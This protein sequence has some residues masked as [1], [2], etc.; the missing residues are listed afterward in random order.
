MALLQKAYLGSTALFRN[1]S[2]FEDDVATLVNSTTGATVTASATTHAK[3]AWTQLL[4]SSSADASLI[5]IGV[6][7]FTTNADTSS[8]LDIGTGASGSETVLIG[9]IAI[10]GHATLNANVSTYIPIPIRVA[11]G[12]R[13]AARI[14]SVVASRAA[15]VRIYLIDTGD[16]NQAPTS[17]DVI[18]A[19]TAT[20][21][22][23]LMSGA[24]GTWVQVTASTSRAYRAVAVVP[25]LA[26]GEVAIIQPMIY[27]LGTGASGSEVEIGKVEIDISNAEFLGYRPVLSPLVAKNIPSGTRLAIKH[28]I[29]S[30]P[31]RYGVTLIGIP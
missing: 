29:S 15:N 17:V 22:G 2:W 19:N 26:S 27:D 31:S 3:G 11:S 30:N 20:S 28:N 9:D 12:T 1:T 4:A 10:G 5:V 6:N 16:Y 7:N 14:Q 25:S 21:N 23:T 24:S 8:L 18:G 13:I